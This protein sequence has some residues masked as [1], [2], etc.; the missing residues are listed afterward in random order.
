MNHILFLFFIFFIFKMTRGENTEYN[1]LE[2]YK[3]YNNQIYKNLEINE[4]YINEL[5]KSMRNTLPR[6]TKQIYENIIH[7]GSKNINNFHSII[8]SIPPEELEINKKFNN[9]LRY[10]TRKINIYIMKAEKIYNNRRKNNK[11]D[12]IVLDKYPLPHNNN[13]DSNFSFF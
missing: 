7:I 12:D 4:K 1:N 8:Y 13:T 10:Y 2:I 6:K 9:D 5:L 3:K 11:Y